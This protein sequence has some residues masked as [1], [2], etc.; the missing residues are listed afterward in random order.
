MQRHSGTL[1]RM[2]K[3]AEGPGKYLEAPHLKT[4]GAVVRVTGI[5]SRRVEPQ[6]HAVRAADRRS[7]TVSVVADAPQR[8]IGSLAVARGR[9]AE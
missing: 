9:R 8:A 2:V 7:P 5:E 4:V 6:V 1:F 3:K